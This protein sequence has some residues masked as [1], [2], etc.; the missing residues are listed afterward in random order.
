MKRI[1]FIPLMFS[2]LLVCLSG[3]AIALPHGPLPPGKVWVE[4]GGKWYRLTPLQE[5]VLISG[6]VVNGYRTQHLRHPDPN[7]FL[8]TGQLKD[9]PG[10]WKAVPSPGMGVK[11]I[12]GYWQ[13]DKWIPGHWDG[14]PPPG[15]HWVPGHRGRGGNWVPGHWR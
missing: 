13:S 1:I 9:G 11:W 5:L 7:G 4:V 8:D 12:P 10:H 14:T 3:Y 2:V 6:G 15:K